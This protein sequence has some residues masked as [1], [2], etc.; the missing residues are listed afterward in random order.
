MTLFVVRYLPKGQWAANTRMSI[1][2]VYRQISSTWPTSGRSTAD[3]VPM[4][5]DVPV[6]QG[7]EDHP[8]GFL[9]HQRIGAVLD[10]HDVEAHADVVVKIV[11]VPA[12]GVANLRT[13]AEMRVREIV[14]TEN[15]P[16]DYK[17]SDGLYTPSGA[18]LE[19]QAAAVIRPPDY[20]A[21]GEPGSIPAAGEAGMFFFL[22]GRAIKNM[23]SEC[24]LARHTK[25]ESRK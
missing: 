23:R 1:K 22:R 11:F 16:G 20:L 21:H 13:G 18:I 10:F 14:G 5:D 12:D 6:I 9:P 2:A 7:L 3:R 15:I 4:G 19:G 24:R 8:H 25:G 17:T